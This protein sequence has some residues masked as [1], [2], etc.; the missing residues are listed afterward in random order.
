MSEHDPAICNEWHGYRVD[1]RGVEYLCPDYPHEVAKP[2][3]AR[4]SPFVW[5][6]PGAPN[7]P[8]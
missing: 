8:A 5:P 2:K 4:Y 3:R 1:R 7:S 6:A